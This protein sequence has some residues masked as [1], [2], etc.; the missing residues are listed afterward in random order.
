MAT[1][2]PEPKRDFK[3]SSSPATSFG[4]AVAGQDHLLT[5]FQQ[6]V[7]GVEKFFLR[8]LLAGQELHV[9]NEQCVQHPVA[10]LE[11]IDGVMLQGAHHVGH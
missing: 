11:L 6:A 8:T 10:A 5:A 3:R 2:S 9:V 4:I 1:V 7:E